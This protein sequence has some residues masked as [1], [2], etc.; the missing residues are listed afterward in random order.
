MAASQALQC[1]LINSMSRNMIAKD[2][3]RVS[4]SSPGFVHLVFTFDKFD[5]SRVM[6][7]GRT[8]FATRE[9]AYDDEDS[10]LLGADP[11]KRMK[12]ER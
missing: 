10:E 8:L 2:M 3:Q 7:Q 12:L 11:K 6:S 9:A 4:D 5:L 1:V